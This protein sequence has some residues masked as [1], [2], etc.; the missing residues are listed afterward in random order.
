MGLINLSKKELIN[1]IEFGD[2]Q[3]P[4]ILADLMCRIIKDKYD[5][6]PDCIIEPTCGKGTILVSSVKTFP[7]QKWKSYIENKSDNPAKVK[8]AK[9]IRV[10][11]MHQVDDH[12]MN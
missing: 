7:N 5:Y 4:K 1:K 11:H 12:G 2:F 6:S 3:T 8:S 9:I 10:D